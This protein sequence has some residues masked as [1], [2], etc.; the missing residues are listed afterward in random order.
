MGKKNKV[1]I[2]ANRAILRA[3]RE[4][5]I[6]YTNMKQ[7]SFDL[8]IALGITI[9]H[10]KSPLHVRALLLA[11]LTGQNFQELISRDHKLRRVANAAPKSNHP[12][13]NY[14]PGIPSASTLERDIKAFY[15]SWE[16]KRLSFDVKQER[17]RTCECCGAKAP[18]V[19]IH[20]DHIKPIRKY[21]HLRLDR[22]NLQVLCEDCNM[23]KG[24]RDET[25]FRALNALDTAPFESELSD[26]ET[27]RMILIKQQL[28]LN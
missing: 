23:G 26:D 18:K 20:T 15:A 4:R 8:A 22:T 7:A 24:S 16:W 3:I 27:A 10:L 6:P 2:E 19:T 28:R 21:W 13:P 9:A 11:K 25:D 1:K 17:G 14:L 5:G 12:K